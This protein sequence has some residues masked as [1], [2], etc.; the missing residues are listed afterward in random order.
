MVN[1]VYTWSL[2]ICPLIVA[3]STEMFTIELRLIY[4][5]SEYT[6]D[7]GGIMAACL[8]TL[9]PVSGVF[10]AF[11]ARI[12]EGVAFMGMRR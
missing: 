5:Q 11:Q 9:L 2:F 12:I 1:W 4:Y 7:Y 8:I 6:I 3:N 10:L